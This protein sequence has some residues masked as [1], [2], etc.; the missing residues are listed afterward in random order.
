MG[1][2]KV[3]YKKELLTKEEKFINTNYQQLIANAPILSVFPTKNN[4][5]YVLKNIMEGLGFK[6]ITKFSN[7]LEVEK[8]KLSNWINRMNLPSGQAL[9]NIACKMNSTIYEMFCEQKLNLNIDISHFNNDGKKRKV[10][11]EEIKNYLLDAIKSDEPKGLKQV[12]DEGGFTDRTAENYFP[13]LCKIVKENFVTYK[14]HLLQK[15]KEEIKEMLKECLAR[16]IPISLTTFS[17][18]YGVPII[19]AKRYAPELSEKVINKNKEFKANKQMERREKIS[20]EIEKIIFDLHSKGM[21][22]SIYNVK[23]RL[24]NPNVL[25]ESIFT[26]HYRTIL[27]SLG[28][29]NNGI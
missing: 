22:P 27:I 19:T 9:L 21:Y 20:K 28:Y 1:D 26:D 10:T 29:E 7:F 12:A 14:K 3:K 13:S 15:K 17:K 25:R 18:E 6:S 23:K 5:G 8:S 11:K 24:S 2:R 4:I 16:E